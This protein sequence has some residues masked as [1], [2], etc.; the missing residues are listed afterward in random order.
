MNN[1]RNEI[2]DLISSNNTI[3]VYY[4]VSLLNIFEKY[5]DELDIV[6]MRLLV[7]ECENCREDFNQT[8]TDIIRKEDTRPN[9]YTHLEI[10]EA[11]LEDYNTESLLTNKLVAVAQ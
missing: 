2:L 3:T 11:K 1:G 4:W 10:L 9:V 5:K 7:A 8:N 6:S